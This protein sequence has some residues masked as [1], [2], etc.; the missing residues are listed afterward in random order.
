MEGAA[1]GGLVGAGGGTLYRL[2]ENRRHDERYRGAYA[3]CMTLARLQQLV[4]RLNGTR[5]GGR[6]TDA[7][8]PILPALT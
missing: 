5:A 2:N 3:S 8:P 6:A 4:A 7:G 1:I